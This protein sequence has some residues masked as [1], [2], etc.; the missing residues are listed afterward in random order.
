[1][2]QKSTFTGNSCLPQRASRERWRTRA[3]DPGL[4]SHTR[5]T[6][7][8]FSLC[9]HVT[10]LGF[11]LA[12][13]LPAAAETPR[14]WGE[15]GFINQFNADF[16][17]D[18]KLD[19]RGGYAR[20]EIVVRAT[21]DIHVRTLVGYHG[22]AYEYSSRPTI[23]GTRFKP[24]NTIH[25]LRINPMV[26][27][28]LREDINLFAGPLVEGAIENGADGGDGVKP[29]GH[30]GA[31]WQVDDTLKVGLGILGVAEIEEGFWLQP[32]LI[33]D[34]QPRDAWRVTASSRTTRGGKFEVSHQINDQ[35]EIGAGV[36]FRRERYRLKERTL[37]TTPPPPVFRTGS[38]GIG[39][40]R[41]WVP[42]GRVSYLPKSAWLNENIG[43]VRIDLEAG[44]AVEGY[45]KLES[46]K[47]KKI[48][49]LDYDA[50]PNLKLSIHIPL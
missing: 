36:S 17:D 20:G 38:E 46:E 34:W 18:G 19:V 10:I 1:M 16:E 45:L 11:V 4:A 22:V 29:G 27:Y 15:V 32:V 9:L 12:A 35:F 31:E 39:E 40:D 43:P 6:R 7:V 30:I 24:W 37:S 21:D 5:P 3:S 23:D 14:S 26:G 50:A 28:S 25:V 8:R 2:S 33:L 49:K 41:A 44:A 47:G 48:E 13:V 42:A